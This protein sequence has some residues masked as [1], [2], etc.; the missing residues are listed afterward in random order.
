MTSRS[1]GKLGLSHL[2]QESLIAG[3]GI[4]L[5]YFSVFLFGYLSFL[6]LPYFF[7]EAAS[8]VAHWL[9]ILEAVAGLIGAV[10]CGHVG[11]TLGR[12]KVLAFTIA[13]VAFPS[14]AISILPDYD[15][16]GIIASIVFVALRLIQMLAFG[17][18]MIGL[19]TFIL[20]DAPADQRGKFGGYMSMS[21]G[22][23]ACIASFL[24]Y[25]V[26]PFSDPDSFWRW[27]L[28]LI[29]GV[30]GMFIANYL[31]KTL[32]G[33]AFFKHHK[34]P[35]E[36][37][38]I[39][40]VLTNNK[41]TVLRVVG[42]TILA[43]IITLTI[44]AWIPQFSVAHF[45]LPARDAML[46]NSGSLI[47]FS[48]GA[49]LFGKWSDKWGRKW[50]LF[51]VGAF[52]LICGHYLFKHLCLTE[53]LLQFI[54]IQ[55]ILSFASSAYY[56]VAMTACIEH[57]PTHIRYTGVAVGYYINY[58]FFGGISGDHIESLLIDGKYSSSS[59]IF[60][61][62]AGAAVVIICSLFL[63]EEAGQVLSD[64]NSQS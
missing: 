29:F 57:V 54:F 47:V 49:C 15:H 10:I 37:Y 8:P 42:L 35:Q 24:L 60:Y 18:D 32:G 56:G 1:I 12:K 55:L 25:L 46:L 19:V 50:I 23:G 22:I 62:M 3:S 64:K 43:P 14:F 4:A 17:G 58:A 21:A 28:L 9:L 52:F 59:P 13:F 45:D 16:I 7:R 30:I 44:Y 51:G 36:S 40:D 53:T 6:I 34:H 2:Q 48:I 26:D 11:D 61:L 31:K 41:L 38:P 5:E 39:I 33:D 63:K 27:R 20:E